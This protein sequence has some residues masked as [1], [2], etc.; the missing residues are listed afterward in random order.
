VD[1]YLMVV[2][3]AL[4][5]TTG[6]LLF[7][8]AALRRGALPRYWGFLPLLT[9]LAGFAWFFLSSVGDGPLFF[10]FPRTLF[11]LGWILMG[12][13]LFSDKRGAIQKLA[14]QVV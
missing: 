4:S 5:L 7:G 8:V 10:I 2:L 12:Y 1:L 6:A 9:G 3:G 11:A 13:M 14:P